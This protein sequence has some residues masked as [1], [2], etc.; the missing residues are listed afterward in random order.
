MGTQS[1][2][3]TILSKMK[4][5]ILVVALLCG[6]VSCAPKYH[7]ADEIPI[8]DC[9]SKAEIQSITFDGRSEFPCVVHQ[10]ETATGQLTMKA[11][12]ATDTLT[13]K[14]VGIIV[15]GIELPF[16]GCPVNALVLGT[17]L[18]RR[19]RCWS[20]TCLSLSSLSTPSWRSPASGC[21][22]MTRGRTSSALP[23]L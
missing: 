7:T 16:N 22:R 10:G 4:H 11:N 21:S 17:V 8:Q 6:L 3:D 5:Y 2:W 19:G 12:S 14:I 1:T 18:L 20:T 9:G 13:C 15:G 23:S